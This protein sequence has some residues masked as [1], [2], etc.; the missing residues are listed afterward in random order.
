VGARHVG[1]GGAAGARQVEKE[2][3]V[4]RLLFWRDKTVSANKR[5]ASL[6][7]RSGE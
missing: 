7:Y 5:A 3:S 1:R 2:R 6:G 4:P